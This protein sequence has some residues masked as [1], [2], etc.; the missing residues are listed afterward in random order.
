MKPEAEQLGSAEPDK[1][2]RVHDLTAGRAHT[3][4]LNPVLNIGFYRIFADIRNREGKP[5]CERAVLDLRLSHPDNL[6]VPDHNPASPD[7]FN[8]MLVLFQRHFCLP[9]KEN[10][11]AGA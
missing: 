9:P 7:C 4:C 10:I 6:T 11:R 3:K 8:N 2:P 1:L 5:F